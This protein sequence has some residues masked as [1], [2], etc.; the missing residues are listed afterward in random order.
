MSGR[1]THSGIREEHTTPPPTIVIVSRLLVVRLIQGACMLL[2]QGRH[3]T[4]TVNTRTRFTGWV[5]KQA[6][7]HHASDRRTGKCT[8][9]ICLFRPHM[10]AE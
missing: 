3:T 7:T 8:G 5:L 9:S 4:P 6:A 1:G 2:P 10:W